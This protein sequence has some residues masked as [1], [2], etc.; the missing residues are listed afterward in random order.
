MRGSKGFGVGH[1]LTPQDGLRAHHS[2]WSVESQDSLPFPLI[3]LLSLNWLVC[4]GRVTHSG[5][6]RVADE[7][8]LPGK[9]W[10]TP[11]RT[12]DECVYFNIN[13]CFRPQKGRC[14]KTIESS[15]IYFPSGPDFWNM[16]QSRMGWRKHL[17]WMILKSTPN[18]LHPLHFLIKSPEAAAVSIYFGMPAL[19]L[20]SF[21]FYITV[22][23]CLL[24]IFLNQLRTTNIRLIHVSPSERVLVSQ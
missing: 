2:W 3:L 10:L 8:S 16:V 20:L 1:D 6:E 13:K 24:N 19:Y 18:N 21:G 15:G 12:E 17:D 22:K 14:C 11:N 4:F 23:K 9:S 7:I 5:R